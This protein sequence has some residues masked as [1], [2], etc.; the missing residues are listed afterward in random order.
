MQSATGNIRPTFVLLANRHLPRRGYLV[1]RILRDG[2]SSDIPRKSNFRTSLFSRKRVAAIFFFRHSHSRIDDKNILN[3]LT[4]HCPILNN[5]KA[6]LSY[7]SVLET[8]TDLEVQQLR[9]K[10]ER[11]A[12]RETNRKHEKQKKRTRNKQTNKVPLLLHTGQIRRCPKRR[13]R[14]PADPPTEDCSHAHNMGA[15]RPPR[16]HQEKRA[17]A[18][19]LR[20]R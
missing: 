17:D 2:P 1:S 13:T 19:G 20:G 5:A 10:C 7:T 14:R 6:R 8:S 9:E 4:R 16:T 15:W 12:C 11:I 18:S 3:A